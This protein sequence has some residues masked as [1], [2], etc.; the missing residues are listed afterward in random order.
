MESCQHSLPEFSCPLNLSA[1]MFS[2]GVIVEDECCR[3]DVLRTSFLTLGVFNP[4][5]RWTSFF[6]QRLMHD[7]FI[8]SRFHFGFLGCLNA[9]MLYETGRVDNLDV[10]HKTGYGLLDFSH[11]SE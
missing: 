1:G 4:P 5:Y 6:S 7:N 11:T 3:L 8:N 9:P 10:S 2:S